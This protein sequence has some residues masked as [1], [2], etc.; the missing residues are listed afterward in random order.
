MMRTGREVGGRVI[1]S[2]EIGDETER[3]GKM[4]AVP[5]TRPTEIL[6]GG[7]PADELLGQKTNAIRWL[8]KRVLEKARALPH[9]FRTR[10]EWEAF[11]ER[12]RKELPRV[13]GMPE[14]PPLR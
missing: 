5:A 9:D 13:I 4:P 2:R 7:L 8:Q 14:L 10:A 1:V 12:M 6:P 11:R 3:E